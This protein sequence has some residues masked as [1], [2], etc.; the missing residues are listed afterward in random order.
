MSPVMIFAC[1]VTLYVLALIYVGFHSAKGQTSEGFVI[2]SRSVGVI[3]TMG[4]LAASFRDGMG[5][6]FWTGIAYT[7]GYGGLWL[8]YGVI[9][10]LTFLAIVGPKV[11]DYAEERDFVTIGDFL[12]NKLGGACEKIVSLFIV[13]KSFLFVSIQL[14]VVGLICANVFGVE[15]YIGIIGSAIV[16]FMYLYFGGY[17]SVVK[18]DALQFFMI[19]GLVLVPFFIQPDMDAVMDFTSYASMGWESSLGLFIIGIFYVVA[20]ADVWQ[21]IF[22]AKNKKTIQ[23]AFPMAGVFLMVM[24][25][26]LIAIGYG[27]MGVMPSDISPDQVLFSLFSDLSVANPYVIAFLG[28]TIMAV[29]MSTL[30]TEAYVFTSSFVRNFLPEKYSVDRKQY[31]QF[32]RGLIGF[33]LA[34]TAIVS[35]AVTDVIQFLFD[36]V[37]LVYVIA[38]LLVAAIFGWA[39]P[40]P[41]QDMYLTASLIV[42]ASVHVYLFLNEGFV[43]LLYNCIPLG[44]SVVLCGISILMTRGLKEEK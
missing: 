27:L 25:L 18:T 6:V 11:R 10:G 4:S 1:A 35:M 13:V 39:K 24:T 43:N 44:V 41:K 15:D 32:S 8:I 40:I 20:G 28:V 3:P 37:S 33:L 7:Y 23:I 19:I 36:A 2:G 31:I 14:Y 34:G 16:I 5:A 26:T 29:S 42:A 12:K 30:D 22:S 9:V 21:R 38:P 17:T